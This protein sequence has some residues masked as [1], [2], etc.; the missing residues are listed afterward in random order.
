MV[1]ALRGKAMRVVT[2]LSRDAVIT[3]LPHRRLC[4]TIEQRTASIAA[5]S[6]PSPPRVGNAHSPRRMMD[7]PQ[8]D[9]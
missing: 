9:R 1:A 5:R 6:M 4:R 3:V 8:D 7:G 2:P